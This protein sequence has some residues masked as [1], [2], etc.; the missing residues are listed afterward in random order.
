MRKLII[1]AVAVAA[2]ALL[3]VPVAARAATP[4]NSG[5]MPVTNPAP[6][7][8][9]GGTGTGSAC[10]FQVDIAV[11]VNDELMDTIS[12]PGGDSITQVVGKLVL[13]FKNDNTGKTLVE[14]VSGPSTTLNRPDG[15]GVE[16]GTGR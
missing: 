2:V 1:G 9:A 11:V 16:T 6:P 4:T 5:W 14:D 7:Y 3:G 15:S 10:S 8:L 13:S 12:L